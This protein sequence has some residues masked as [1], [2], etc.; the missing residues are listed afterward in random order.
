M[1]NFS[2]YNLY[3]NEIKIK[4][5]NVVKRKGKNEKFISRISY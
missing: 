5:Y 4:I 1:N 2:F 3:K